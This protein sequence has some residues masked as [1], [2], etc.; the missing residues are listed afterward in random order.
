M[1]KNK[2]LYKSLQII[3]KTNN[4]QSKDHLKKSDTKLSYDEIRKLIEH[5]SEKEMSVKNQRKQIKNK[6][7][8][9]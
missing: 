1:M 4:D 6:F 8:I 7:D 2:S 3:P 5:E 9:V